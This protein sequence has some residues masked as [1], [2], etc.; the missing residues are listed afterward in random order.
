MTIVSPLV[1]ALALAFIA[2]AVV[3]SVVS[4]VVLARFVTT[5]RRVRLTRHES[6][7]TYYR[8]LALTH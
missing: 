7:G 2:V 4:V 6:V 1:L 8:S 5:N 3:A